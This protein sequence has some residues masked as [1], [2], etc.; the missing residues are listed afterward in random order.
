MT[1]K[2]QAPRRYAVEIKLTAAR[3]MPP[4]KR[5]LSAHPLKI[6][7]IDDAEPRLAVRET[8]IAVRL[9]ADELAMA[10]IKAALFRLFLILSFAI[11]WSS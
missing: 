11:S 7:T 3:L 8:N 10:R 4:R 5:R 2:K 6:A 9:T 1:D